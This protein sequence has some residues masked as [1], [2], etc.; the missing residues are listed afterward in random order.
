MVCV[1]AIAELHSCTCT[2]PLS[3]LA[4]ENR[5]RVK[6]TCSPPAAAS[7]STGAIA[8]RPALGLMTEVSRCH[9]SQ[10]PLPT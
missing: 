3:I 9:P 8:E 2:V 5:G 6:S 10:V 1:V 7:G 4:A